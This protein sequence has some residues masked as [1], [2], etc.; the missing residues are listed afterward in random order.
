M[1]YDWTQAEQGE[2]QSEQLPAGWH[3]VRIAR[4]V[5]RRSSGEPFTSRKGD[6]QIMVV[7]ADDQNREATRMYTLS[8]AAAWTLARLLSRTGHDL[9]RLKEE[10]VEPRHFA[11][12]KFAESRL[13][14]RRTWAH[15]TWTE[16]DDRGRQF[17]DV[18]PLHEHELPQEVRARAATAGTGAGARTGGQQQRFRHPDVSSRDEIPF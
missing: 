7:F 12:R 8:E 10:G 18:T 15:V 5:T 13:L 14:G 9:E 6:P 17:S 4:I 16:P 2:T 1:V 11:N 3:P